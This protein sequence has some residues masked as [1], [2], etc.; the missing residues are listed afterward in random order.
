MYEY[1]LKYDTNDL[2]KINLWVDL[3]TKHGLS[4]NNIE[5]L[6]VKDKLKNFKDEV[7]N[8]LTDITVKQQKGFLQDDFTNL[9][10]LKKELEV[11]KSKFIDDTFEEFLK[12]RQ[13]L[14]EH[15]EILKN[16]IKSI[17]INSNI[18]TGLKDL[19]TIIEIAKDADFNNYDDA[20]PD[21][22]GII[23]IYNQAIERQKILTQEIDELI[24]VELIRKTITRLDVQNPN[25]VHNALD[26][27]NIDSWEA[28]DI[29]IKALR[30]QI[31]K[32][33]TLRG[34]TKSEIQKKS[35][36]K[37]KEAI[38]YR[39]NELSDAIA[40]SNLKDSLA[41][42]LNKSINTATTI[43]L[44]NTNTVVIKA[45]TR[46]NE[47]KKRNLNSL[48]DVK[49]DA[50]NKIGH[51]NSY[52]NWTNL[53]KKIN[54]TVNDLIP[55]DNIDVVTSK[56]SLTKI[57]DDLKKSI[58]EI[59]TVINE[60]KEIL[61]K[62]NTDVTVEMIQ[63]SI[64]ELERQ[65]N[66]INDKELLN[67]NQNLIINIETTI[68]LFNTK[69][70]NVFR[71]PT[72]GLYYNYNNNNILLFNGTLNK[73]IFIENDN[74]VDIKM[75]HIICSNQKHSIGSTFK[76]VNDEMLVRNKVFLS[77]NDIVYLPTN[78]KYIVNNIGGTI[79]NKD[80]EGGS[81]ILRA[82]TQG[83]VLQFYVNYKCHEHKY[84]T[85]K[86]MNYARHMNGFLFPAS[87]VNKKHD[88]QMNRRQINTN[89][90]KITSSGRQSRLQA[91]TGSL[92]RLQRLKA[93][94]M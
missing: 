64:S 78:S 91:N 35:E 38:D 48:V 24:S 27:T 42:D 20:K 44:L 17:T 56:N 55:T 8:K 29:D 18:N 25:D 69:K 72:N 75:L 4:Q 94:H 39:N 52:S 68:E 70:R 10:L 11:A 6:S 37:L 58:G 90:K 19:D 77:I 82:R 53:N 31:A 51:N 65:K 43:G 50:L 60:K 59:E 41:K 15:E 36:N 30:S 62:K 3:S 33:E 87:S 85:T 46:L 32:M 89:I 63:N 73:N 22:T 40:K 28:K 13:L 5:L 16:R 49:M 66:I 1:A 54:N 67:I 12:A 88:Y 80:I 83:G 23:D 61:N 9:P 71:R 76:R 14:F 93:K 26:T 34:N 2:Q 84:Q 45:K 86:R 7:L 74:S 47:I 81:I 79:F 92:S 21:K 57:L